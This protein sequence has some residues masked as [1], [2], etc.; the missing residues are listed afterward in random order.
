MR[1]KQCVL[2]GLHR[3]S[4]F[5]KPGSDA[6]CLVVP[7]M[8]LGL[9]AL[10]A[11]ERGIPIIAVNDALQVKSVD[12]TEYV[13]AVVVGDYLEAAGAVAALRAGVSVESLRRPL[14][15]VKVSRPGA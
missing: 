7:R 11:H 5:G 3:A 15:K 10:A 12:C 8:C 4:R 14:A 1:P 13:D 2:K 6:S 9:P